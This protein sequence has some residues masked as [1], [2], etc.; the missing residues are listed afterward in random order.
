[1][2]TGYDDRVNALGAHASS[3]LVAVA[4]AIVLIA[5]AIVP[6][7]TPSWVA[8]EQGR[9]EA[10]AWTG[11]TTT[12]L[13]TAT[14]SILGDLVLGGDFAVQVDGKAVLNDRER[15]HMSDV[16]N[17]FRG[18]WVL[19]LASLVV[20]AAA[21]RRMD[22]ARLWRSI[23]RGA[24]GLTVGVVVAGV[25]GLVAFDQLFEAFHE[26]FFPAGSFLFDPATDRLVQLFPFAFWQESAMVA[27]ALIIAL[28]LVVAFLAGRRA[29][30]GVRDELAPDLAVAARPGS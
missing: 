27:G 18:L 3:I 1:V 13:R 25:V 15:A 26:L 5:V 9:A 14:D 10:A 22:R 11:Y 7:L 20:L 16:R 8:F 12:Q 28:A 17:V 29:R 4:A 6:L 2:R 21:S 24:L 30:Q 23:R 19:A